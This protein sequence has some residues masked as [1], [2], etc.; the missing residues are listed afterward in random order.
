MKADIIIDAVFNDGYDAWIVEVQ[1][2]EGLAVVHNEY[3][4]EEFEDAIDGIK[5]QYEMLGKKVEV[6]IRQG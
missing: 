4:D 5:K 3:L 2:E 6:N 1:N